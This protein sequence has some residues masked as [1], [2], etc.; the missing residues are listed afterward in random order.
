MSE[1]IK[2]ILGD[3]NLEFCQL[4]QRQLKTYTTVEVVGMAQD[5]VEL[6]SL[7]REKPL[8]VLTQS[9]VP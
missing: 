8:S 3:D 5:G 7:V 2:V 4:L 1:H 6:L 9:I